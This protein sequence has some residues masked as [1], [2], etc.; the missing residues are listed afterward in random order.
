[1]QIAS[2][3]RLG[4]LFWCLSTIYGAILINV[5]CI[6][7]VN[8]AFY[9]QMAHNQYRV[10][11]TVPAFRGAIVDRRGVPLAIN[12]DMISAFILPNQLKE[13]ER[14]A[15]FLAH[16][17]PTA[18]QRLQTATKTGFMYIKRNLTKLQHTMIT[19][20]GLADIKLL[21]E[22]SRYYPFPCVATVV[23]MTDIDN[24][25][26]MGIEL[27]CNHT[28]SG[29]PHV[30][31][32]EKDA[33]S[34]LFYFEKATQESGTHGATVQLTIDSD[35]QFVIAQELERWVALFGAKQGAVVVLD[36]LQ[37]DIL[38]LVSCPSFDPNNTSEL[39]LEKTKNIP[40][41]DTYEL[42]SVFKVFAALAAL[43]EH[44]VKPDDLIDCKNVASA[45]VHGRRVNT[46]AS[47][48]RAVVPFWEVI[49]VS[50]NI[51]IALVAHMLKEK[52]YDHYVKLGFASK[53]GLMVPNEPSGYINH[54]KNWS[55]QSVISLSYG[56]EVSATLVQLARAFSVFA[57]VL[58]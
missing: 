20:S 36:P 14:V 24:K 29:T 13:P 17:F 37:G 55:A 34:G 49:A 40:V 4:W 32:L 56:Y 16:H 10:V 7:I 5:F 57:R 45:W 1:M 33:R 30:S 38:A 19:Q 50:N 27:S 2:K 54:P 41:C 53:I 6:Q 43:E 26:Q 31:T 48:V 52:L 58:F 51:G 11:Q 35:L 15:E 44:V 22:P 47:T 39:D 9:K 21:K 46:V 12:Q 42:G 8:H 18:H 28:L 23:G 25:G 3:T